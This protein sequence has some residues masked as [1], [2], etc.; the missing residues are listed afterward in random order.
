M[1]IA[2]QIDARPALAKL[3][4]AGRAIAPEKL[5]AVAGRAIL[6]QVKAHLRERNAT[7]N[8]LGGKRTNY[9]AKAA[10]SVHAE[11]DAASARISV[12]H[13]G[14]ALH[15]YGGTVR[16]V[17]RKYLT[18]PIA[19]EAHGARVSD[20]PGAFVLRLKGKQPVIALRKWKGR[21]P[22]ALQLLFALVRQ[23][24]IKADPSV[25]PSPGTSSESAVLAINA[26]LTRQLATIR[27]TP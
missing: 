18:I 14:M 19:A 11:H 16:P 9:Y 26:Y 1:S 27:S 8:R 23:A 3:A 24:T 22:G 13:T 25:M 20:F 15:Y 10:Q 5:H 12:S 17:N 4:A 2:I 6:N 21:T 7:A